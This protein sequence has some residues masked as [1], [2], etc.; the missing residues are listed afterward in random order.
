M[1][2]YEKILGLVLCVLKLFQ[3]KLWIKYVYCHCY[4]F[5]D[6]S[7]ECRRHLS[8]RMT[9]CR[10]AATHVHK[11]TFNFLKQLRNKKNKFLPFN[12]LWK[13]KTWYLFLKEG[14]YIR[15]R[16]LRLSLNGDLFIPKY[17]RIN[18][19]AMTITISIADFIVV[20]ASMVVFTIGSEGQIFAA[21]AIRYFIILIT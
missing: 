21:S 20:V 8:Q 5:Y 17:I 7:Q 4:I 2:N 18:H 19:V 1:K 6:I 9:G 11:K 14:Y 16:S 12:Y 3:N 13:R 15:L 10:F